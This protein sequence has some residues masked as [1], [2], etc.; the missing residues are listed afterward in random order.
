MKILPLMNLSLVS[1][2]LYGCAAVPGTPATDTGG[3]V[4]Q[5]VTSVSEQSEGIT[6]TRT[7]LGITGSITDT[8]LLDEMEADGA[9]E[10]HYIN[11]ALYKDTDILAAFF[12]YYAGGGYQ[13]A[14]RQLPS[15]VIAVEKR[16]ISEGSGDEPGG[17]GP[18]VRLKEYPTLPTTTITWQN[19]GTPTDEVVIE[20]EGW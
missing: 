4:M 1:L 9:A 7:S 2:A 14:V 15:G 20:C 6:L 8:L 10:L 16:G 3:I 11:P 17:C 19:T 12:T 5:P 18:W 13:I